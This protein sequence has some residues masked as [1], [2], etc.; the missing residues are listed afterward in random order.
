MRNVSVVSIN[1]IIEDTLMF[2]VYAGFSLISSCCHGPVDNRSRQKGQTNPHREQACYWGSLA[3]FHLIVSLYFYIV[4]E[5]TEEM[6]VCSF[7]CTCNVHIF[8]IQPIRM[9]GSWVCFDYR[10]LEEATVLNIVIFMNIKA[11]T[12]KTFRYTFYSII[13]QMEF[14]ESL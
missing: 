1:H 5:N 11:N 6:A 7:R 2:R 3:L 4:F 8:P 13:N 9:T 14:K 12:Y 10:N